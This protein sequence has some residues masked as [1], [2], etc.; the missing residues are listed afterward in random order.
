[1]AGLTGDPA[2][3]GFRLWLVDLHSDLESWDL[4]GPPS[5]QD[6]HNLGAPWTL[7]PLRFLE[8][9]GSGF[10]FWLCPLF[11]VCDCGEMVALSMSLPVSEVG[12]AGPMQL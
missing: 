12:M 10:K 9:M 4:Q 2:S 3:L 8:R 6:Q 7:L 11:A 5:S 1:M